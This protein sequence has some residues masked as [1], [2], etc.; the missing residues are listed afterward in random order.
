M[1]K[2]SDDVVV[3]DH[4]VGELDEHVGEPFGGN[5]CHEHL[6]GRGDALGAPLAIVLRGPDRLQRPADHIAGR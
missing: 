1:S 6:S 3:F 5:A 2:N 4:C